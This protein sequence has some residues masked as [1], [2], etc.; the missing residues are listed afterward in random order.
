MPKTARLCRILARNPDAALEAIR[1][2][3]GEIVT[4]EKCLIH[5]LE[6]NFPGFRRET[7]GHFPEEMP[8]CG[9]SR[10]LSTLMVSGGRQ[11]SQ[12]TE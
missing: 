11:A 4:G 12:N 5:L 1:L 10:P 7:E 9:A 2:P 8:I 3:D 6:E